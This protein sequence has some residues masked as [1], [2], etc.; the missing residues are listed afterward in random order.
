MTALESKTKLRKF[1]HCST[2]SLALWPFWI[3]QRALLHP[4]IPPL[5]HATHNNT[6][7]QFQ[8]AVCPPGSVWGHQSVQSAG[9]GGETMSWETAPLRVAHWCR[10]LKVLDI[11][12][13]E[14]CIYVHHTSEHEQCLGDEW[15]H[16]FMG[17]RGGG[18]WDRP[19]WQMSDDCNLSSLVWV[20]SVPWTSCPVIS[21]ASNRPEVEEK[22]ETVVPTMLMIAYHTPR[23][24]VWKV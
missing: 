16:L 24:A 19:M 20:E 7:P 14:M 8:V 12:A 1:S 10:A 3:Q 2:G 9:P 22:Q 17:G 4:P 5:T 23:Q 6:L 21:A 15:G 13:M 18:D 11:Q